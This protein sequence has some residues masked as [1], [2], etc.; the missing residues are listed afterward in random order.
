[1]LWRI[2]S[3]VK[4]VRFGVIHIAAPGILE[5]VTRALRARWGSDVEVLTRPATPVLA[6]HVGRG[7][8]GVAYLVED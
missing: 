2:P 3:A 8:W 7:A 5:P 6:T 1:M 4:R